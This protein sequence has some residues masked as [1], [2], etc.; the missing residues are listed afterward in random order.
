MPTQEQIEQETSKD[1]GLPVE[2]K[3]LSDRY[4]LAALD[5]LIAMQARDGFEISNLH[6]L[7]DVMGRWMEKERVFWSIQH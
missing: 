4:K 2:I 3:P 6:G 1:P 7:I 5:L